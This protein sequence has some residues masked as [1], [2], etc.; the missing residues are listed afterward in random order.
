MT[1][2]EII[3]EV[4]FKTHDERIAWPPLTAYRICCCWRERKTSNY[5]IFFM[6]IVSSAPCVRVL[7]NRLITP[8]LIS[9]NWKWNC[10]FPVFVCFRWIVQ[11]LSQHPTM[12]NL[13]LASQIKCKIFL[14]IIMA[15]V[16]VDASQSK[17]STIEGEGCWLPWEL[18]FLPASST[19]PLTAWYRLHWQW[20]FWCI[21][22]SFRNDWL[23]RMQKHRSSKLQRS[24]QWNCWHFPVGAM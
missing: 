1:Q 22:F 3:P 21:I 11:Q 23:L 8:W 2:L 14:L 5:L 19:W 13:C 17:W 4:L 24:I 15:V 10:K 6:L 7:L 12:L 9:K 20:S 18:V 16:D